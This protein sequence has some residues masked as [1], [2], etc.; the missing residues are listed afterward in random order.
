MRIEAQCRNCHLRIRLDW[1]YIDPSMIID[2]H[3]FKDMINE[4]KEE[5]CI[6]CSQVIGE[7]AILDSLSRYLQIKK[8]SEN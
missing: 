3:E 6:R 7:Q 2:Q 5:K 4:F 1:V 8:D